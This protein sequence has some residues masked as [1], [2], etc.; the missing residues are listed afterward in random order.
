MIMVVALSL[1]KPAKN[2]FKDILLGGEEVRL[3]CVSRWVSL[4]PWTASL[5]CTCMLK[6]KR[7]NFKSNF[8][9]PLAASLNSSSYSNN[10]V[11]V[12]V[13]VCAC[14]CVLYEEKGAS[15]AQEARKHY[16]CYYKLSRTLVISSGD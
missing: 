6:I 7:F 13:H 3:H 16:H 5:H 4:F 9:S 2:P 11:C 14:V 10:S 8:L 12:C 1:R 15:V